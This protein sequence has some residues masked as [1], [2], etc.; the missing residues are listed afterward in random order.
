MVIRYPSFYDDGFVPER[1]GRE[2]VEA[3][4][5]QALASAYD[6]DSSQITVTTLGSY[7]ILS[8]MVRSPFE[9]LRAEEIAGDIVGEDYVR[10]RLLHRMP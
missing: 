6:I 9:R 5:T 7:V 3:A 4:V 8:G 10:S 1:S 2:A